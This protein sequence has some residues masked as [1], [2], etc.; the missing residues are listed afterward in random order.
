MDDGSRTVKLFKGE[1]LY[2]IEIAELAAEDARKNG[3]AVYIGS[4]IK[5]MYRDN[6]NPQGR[7]FDLVSLTG[8]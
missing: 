4:M 1:K 7:Q 3:I 8:K 5:D 2:G 6:R